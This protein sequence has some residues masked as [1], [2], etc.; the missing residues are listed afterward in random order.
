MCRARAWRLCDHD[1]GG[2]GWVAL[3]NDLGPESL[4]FQICRGLLDALA[5]DMGTRAV[6]GFIHVARDINTAANTTKPSS[7]PATR[8]RSYQRGS[9]R[10]PRTTV[11]SASAGSSTAV[12]CLTLRASSCSV[13]TGS[14]R[15]PTGDSGIARCLSQ[16]AV[17]VRTMSCRATSAADGGLSAGLLAS[18]RTPDSRWLLVCDLAAALEV[19]A[20]APGQPRPGCQPGPLT[21]GKTLIR[22]SFS[23]ASCASVKGTRA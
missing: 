21:S 15:A 4:L 8:R 3:L 19:R 6:P 5:L 13:A 11:G 12:S 16:V 9:R 10:E 23:V 2:H 22:H 7:A 18:I 1:A 20:G 14:D 17:S